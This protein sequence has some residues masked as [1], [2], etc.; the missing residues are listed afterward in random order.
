MRAL[1][2]THAFLWLLAGDSALSDAARMILGDEDSTICVSA[3][4]AWEITTKH[5]LGNLA[6]AVALARTIEL[7]G[8]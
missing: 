4:T 5:R 2:D 7:R 6:G 3:A 8:T 1:F